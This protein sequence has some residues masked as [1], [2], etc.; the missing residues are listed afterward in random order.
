MVPSNKS[1]VPLLRSILGAQI[2]EYVIFIA[3]L[4]LRFEGD[5]LDGR[6]LGH[7]LESHPQ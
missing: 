4:G 6:R 5:I 2:L 1:R 7:G 3:F